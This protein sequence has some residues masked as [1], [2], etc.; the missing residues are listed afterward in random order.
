MR[1]SKS[2]D[3]QANPQPC[4]AWLVCA[5]CPRKLYYRAD[6]GTGRQIAG[7]RPRSA[8][9]GPRPQNLLVAKG[10]CTTG[11]TL[12][13]AGW[14][15]PGPDLPPEAPGPEPVSCQRKLHYRADSQGQGARWLDPGSGDLPTRASLLVV[16]FVCLLGGVESLSEVVYCRGTS[17]NK[18]C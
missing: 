9:R 15:D 16:V 7:S 17:S 12:R 10:S 6:S 2:R 8:P 4:S 3:P 5:G 11:P 14:P 1:V 13:D 18:K